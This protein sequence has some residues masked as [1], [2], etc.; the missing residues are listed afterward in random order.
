MYE[1]IARGHYYDS[2]PKSGAKK[3]CSNFGKKTESS[4]LHKHLNSIRLPPEI[5]G[6]LCIYTGNGDPVINSVQCGEQSR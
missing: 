1:I 4:L 2:V 6:W 5:L 3:S